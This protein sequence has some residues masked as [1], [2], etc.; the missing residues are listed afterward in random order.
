M[1]LAS[2][3]IFLFLFLMAASSAAFWGLMAAR[4]QMKAVTRHGHHHPYSA[5]LGPHVHN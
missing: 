1:D 2:L 5:Q 4:R 3:L